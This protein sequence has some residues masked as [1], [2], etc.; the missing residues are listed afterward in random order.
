[1]W[2]CSWSNHVGGLT[3]NQ[4][5]LFFPVEILK[6]F[7]LGGLNRTKRDLLIYM[8]RISAPE[9]P[10][11]WLFFSPLYWDVISFHPWMLQAIHMYVCMHIC[12]NTNMYYVFLYVCTY[13]WV[14][15]YVKC[16]Y[17]CTCVYMYEC[18]HLMI[19]SMCICEHLFMVVHILSVLYSYVCV[20]MC[21]NMLIV[22]LHVDTCMCVCACACERAYWR[23]CGDI[24]AGGRRQEA[25]KQNLKT[26]ERQ[27]HLQGSSLE[28]RTETHLK[29]GG[30]GFSLL[31]IC[32]ITQR[33]LVIW[34][35]K[36]PTP[37]PSSSYLSVPSFLYFSPFLGG[38]PNT[39]VLCTLPLS[40][41]PRLWWVS[42]WVMAALSIL[43]SLM[44]HDNLWP[45]PRSHP[46]SS[47]EKGRFGDI[48]ADGAQLSLIYFSP[49]GHKFATKRERKE[50]V[51]VKRW[52][53][54]VNASWSSQEK[55]AREGATNGKGLTGVTTTAHHQWEDSELTRWDIQ[56]RCGQRETCDR[57][58]LCL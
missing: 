29:A 14:Q 43:G 38:Q 1:M 26:G 45:V 47:V 19:L 23:H 21:R 10:L 51:G 37:Q 50:E 55:T 33:A 42:W 53:G 28:A 27:R 4:Q 35:E 9:I 49:L 15:A 41:P 24:V 46:V 36:H 56:D 2:S 7:L 12:I 5:I 25:K 11:H 30:K 3:E 6:D 18:M 20:H 22:L 54:E 58:T 44:A 52:H 48:R 31:S 8:I 17:V 16:L 34:S 39:V 40:H 57:P 13:A 32:T